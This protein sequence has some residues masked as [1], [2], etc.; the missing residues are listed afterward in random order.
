MR[1]FDPTQAFPETFAF[2][3]VD[4]ATLAR[5][6]A[7]REEAAFNPQRAMQTGTGA[8]HDYARKVLVPMPYTGHGSAS[9]PVS[10]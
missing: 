1:S 3:D 10:A 2:P 6:D 4:A 5:E 8:W 9:R 7:V